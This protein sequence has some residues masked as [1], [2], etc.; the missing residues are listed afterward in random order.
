[1]N[2]WCLLCFAL[3]VWVMGMNSL[4]RLNKIMCDNSDKDGGRKYESLG[5]FLASTQYRHTVE[6]SQMV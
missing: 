3:S 6:T 4:I 2:C 5:A 1:M